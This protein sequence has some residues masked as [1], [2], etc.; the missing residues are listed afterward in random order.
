[1]TY[2][3]SP[4]RVTENSKI[5]MCAPGDTQGGILP[6]LSITLSIYVSYI[7]ANDEFVVEE[8]FS[9]FT[10]AAI[11]YTND[12]FIAKTQLTGTIAHSFAADIGYTVHGP[13][14]KFH[15]YKDN[16][17]RGGP[18]C[19]VYLSSRS[20]ILRS[21]SPE[22]YYPLEVPSLDGELRCLLQRAWGRGY[23]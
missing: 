22:V 7:N 5:Y 19:C 11:D 4:P 12:G 17:Y 10:S 23:S 14:F 9:D 6:W 20:G 21:T 13:L 16:Y 2:I 15:F 1:M 18:G 3:P 8:V